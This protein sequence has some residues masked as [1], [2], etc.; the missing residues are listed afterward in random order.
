M[1][2]FNRTFLCLL[3]SCLCVFSGRLWADSSVEAVNIN[4]ADAVVLAKSLKGIGVNKAQAIVRYRET[5]GEFKSAEEL[6]EIKG[7]GVKL[8]EANRSRIKL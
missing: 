4:T 6:T 5:V 3:L 7:I 1:N 2:I 8:I